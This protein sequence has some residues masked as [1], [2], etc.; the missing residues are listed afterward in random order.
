[1]YLSEITIEGYRVFDE[2]K[3]INFNKG[4]NLLVGENGSGKSTIID[5]I[6]L[7]LNEDEHSRSGINEEDF[8]SSID[9]TV[10]SEKNFYKRKIY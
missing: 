8:Y 7:L 6:R 1:M 4:L 10:Q 2:S 9:K 5:A 3:T